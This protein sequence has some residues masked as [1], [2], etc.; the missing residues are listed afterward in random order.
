MN[1][2]VCVMVVLLLVVGSAMPRG[3]W[4]ASESNTRGWALM[5]P[6]ERIEHQA[7]IRN[8]VT[9]AECEAY[10]AEHRRDMEARAAQL[11]KQLQGG[12]RDFCEHLRPSPA[13]TQPAS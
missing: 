10:Q 2:H 5:S 4:R 3:P 7:R 6:Q 12:G 9:P 13:R 11:N 8:F 1:K